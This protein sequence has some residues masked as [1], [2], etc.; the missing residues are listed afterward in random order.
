MSTGCPGTPGCSSTRAAGRRMPIA[1]LERR[2]DRLSMAAKL[3][4]VGKIG[5]SDSILKKPGKLDDAEFATMQMHTIIGSRL[6]NGL[7][8]DYGDVARIVA[9]H[10]HEQWDG[11]GYPVTSLDEFATDPPEEPIRRGLAGEAI[12]IEARIVGLA[13]VYD[14]LSSKRS[15]KD[16]WPE[17]RVIEEIRALSGTHFDPELVELF[18]DN[19]DRIRLV[20]DTFP[21][22]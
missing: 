19:I 8:T 10:H 21:R 3:H 22:G 7:Q 9:L 17:D 14:A 2:R 5:I 13:D 18:L 16:A 6:F 12:P 20:R 11:Q 15:Y 4:D 1:E